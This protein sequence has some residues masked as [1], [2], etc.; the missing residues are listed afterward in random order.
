MC[1]PDGQIGI[2]ANVP[3]ADKMGNGNS[4]KLT[5]FAVGLV[6]GALIGILFASKSGEETREYLAG[7]SRGMTL[8]Y[9]PQKARDLRERVEDLFERSKEAAIGPGPHGPGKPP[10]D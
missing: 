6:V 9:A 5:F 1:E 8:G 2:L 4:S 3:M 7:E 10:P